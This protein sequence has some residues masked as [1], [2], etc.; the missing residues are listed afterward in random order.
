MNTNCYDRVRI[1]VKWI[2][3]E[4]YLKWIWKSSDWVQSISENIKWRF[5]SW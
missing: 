4:F 1:K 3:F 2:P 5:E